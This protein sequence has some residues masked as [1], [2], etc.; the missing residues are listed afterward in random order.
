[1]I[2]LPYQIAFVADL[3]DTHPVGIMNWMVLSYS[4]GPDASAR[5]LAHSLASHAHTHARTKMHTD[6]DARV[7]ARAQT[8][9]HLQVDAGFAIDMLLN[10]F[11]MFYQHDTSVLVVLAASPLRATGSVARRVQP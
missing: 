7:R 9:T 6:S 4:L 2:V 10:F 1:M 11:T 5:T 8:H 3:A